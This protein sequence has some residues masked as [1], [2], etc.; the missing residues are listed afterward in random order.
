MATA[1][2]FKSIENKHDDKDYIKKF[3]KSLREH[4]MEIIN[5]KRKK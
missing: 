4:V 3:R 2:P 5:F 1:F